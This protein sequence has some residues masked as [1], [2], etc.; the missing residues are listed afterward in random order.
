[1]ETQ[2]TRRL[3]VDPTL[4]HAQWAAATFGS[5]AL[6]DR[7]LQRRVVTVASAIAQSPQVSLCRSCADPAA[8]KA[9][10]RL[11]QHPAA[12]LDAM[13][14]PH[15]E[16]T[17][18]ATRAAAGVVLLIQDTTEVDYSA[19]RATTGL[20]PIGDGRG[21]GFL[22]QSV[23]AVQPG[24][25]AA[26]ATVLGVAH[27]QAFDRVPAP[28]RGEPSAE[29][30]TR[31]RESDVWLTAVTAIGPPPAA[32]P[33]VMV[34]D[35][36]AD[37]FRLFA[38]C[39][40]QGQEVLVRAVQ[41]RRATDPDGETTHVVEHARG[42]APHA[43]RRTITVPARAGQPGRE[44]EVVIGWSPLQV[45]PPART[46]DAVELAM[47][48]VRVW[49]PAPP[50]GTP[51]LEWILLTS[52]PT[53]TSTAAWERV[54]WYRHRWI[55]EEYHHALKT[56]CRLEAS[57]LRDQDRL[58][59]LLGVCAP[60]A[61]RLL[62]LRMAARGDPTAPA[63]SQFDAQTVAVVA[64]L[65]QTSATGM[66]LGT[67]WRLIARLGGHLGRKGDGEPGWKTLWWGWQR[68]QATLDGM[69]LAQVLAAR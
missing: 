20:G 39:R 17:L 53:E 29:R 33:W 7:R 43:E 61:V 66:T 50:A 27:V 6:G 15:R 8:V 34:G 2:E 23:L 62:Q 47:W 24:P 40:A 69:H 51:A 26:Q 4:P 19:H 56:G 52:V 64:A 28:R 18:A 10:Y 30:R 25:T 45:Q 65:T 13:T 46:T 55:I 1:M 3:V 63:T 12:T 5:C 48:V 11:F 14:A 59:A 49:E 60:I 9:A 21:R 57:Q 42:L 35:R 37:A 32:R 58:W 54:A 68:L 36:G 22:V 16:R 38:H 67:C 31:A 44:A 41:D